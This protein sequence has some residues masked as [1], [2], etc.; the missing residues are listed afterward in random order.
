MFVQYD[1]ELIICELC[2]DIKQKDMHWEFTEIKVSKNENLI[3][4]KHFL[5]MDI[6]ASITYNST[7][8]VTCIHKIQMEG[9][10]SQNVDI[11]LSF[12]FR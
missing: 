3:F 10:V 11:G 2:N 5:N 6:L 4:C 12:H 9:S 7:K 1:M 8:F